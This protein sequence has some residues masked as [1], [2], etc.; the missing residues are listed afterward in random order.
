MCIPSFLVIILHGSSSLFCILGSYVHVTGN[1]KF[2]Q[3]KDLSASHLQ[4]NNLE[5]KVTY[6]TRLWCSAAET[7]CLPS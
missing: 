3:P 7:A 2:L 1:S 5:G 6:Q 4:C